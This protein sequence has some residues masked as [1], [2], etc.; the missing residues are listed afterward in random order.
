MIR[1]TE[2]G[3]GDELG[4]LVPRAARFRQVCELPVQH[5]LE[6]QTV[7]ELTLEKPT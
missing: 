7:E 1:L 3:V 4:H 2:E 5:P 6:L